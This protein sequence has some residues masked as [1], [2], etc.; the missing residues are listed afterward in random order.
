MSSGDWLFVPTASPNS[1]YVV[2]SPTARDP[3]A[4]G[5]LASS[6]IM[7]GAHISRRSAGAVYSGCLYLEADPDGGTLFRGDGS[8]WVQAAVGV[9]GYAFPTGAAGG[10]LAGTYPN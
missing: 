7:A 6:V 3:A 1:S 8:E 5:V 2:L 10:D 4:A 9:A